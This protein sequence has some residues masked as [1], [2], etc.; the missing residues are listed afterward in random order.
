M[1]GKQC[2]IIRD[3]YNFDG[4]TNAVDGLCPDIKFKFRPMSNMDQAMWLDAEEK[5]K[6]SRECVVNAQSEVIARQLVSWDAEEMTAD[7]KY[8]PAEINEESIKLLPSEVFSQLLNI[9]VGFIQRTDK[10]RKKA[11]EKA[12]T[13]SEP[14]KSELEE[15]EKN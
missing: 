1:A 8:K 10:L 7:G 13:E 15:S 6:D 12:N 11:I 14:K 4:D 2:A 9:V 3:G 5:N